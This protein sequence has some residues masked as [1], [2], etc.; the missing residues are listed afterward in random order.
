MLCITNTTKFVSLCANSERTLRFSKQRKAYEQ[1]C[2][3][4]R[5]LFIYICYWM[6]VLLEWDW[7]PH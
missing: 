4:L 2:A 3:D 7:A 1:E 5:F 6:C